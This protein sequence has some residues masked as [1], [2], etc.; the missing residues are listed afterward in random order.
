MIEMLLY[1]II[2]L[3]VDQMIPNSQYDTVI[4]DWDCMLNQTN[5]GQNNNKYYIIQMLLG[6]FQAYYVWTRWGRVVCSYVRGGDKD[7]II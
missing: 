2:V 7:Y 5:I 1:T 3:Q 4:D 6:A